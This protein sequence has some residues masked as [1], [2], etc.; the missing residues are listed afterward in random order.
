LIFVTVGTHTQGFDRLVKNIDDLLLARKIKEKVIIQV[1][2]GNYIPKECEWFR[3]TSYENFI[4]LCENSRLTITHGGVGSIISLLRLK[5]PTIVVP[6][7]KKFNEHIDDHQLH[8]TK[9]LERQ[10]KIIAVYDISNLI[11]AINIAK[12]WKPSKIKSK[13]YI[14]HIIK[15]FI[16]NQVNTN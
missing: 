16:E 1:G 2:H 5:K 12:K 6:R 9:E 10:K 13:N 15:N 7:L 3:F 8:I 11:N 4:K 14:F